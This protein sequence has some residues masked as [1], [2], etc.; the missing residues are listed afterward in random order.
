MTALTQTISTWP[1]AP[2]ADAGVARPRRW[3]SRRGWPTAP[4]C[5]ARSG[6]P[7]SP[8]RRRSSGARRPGDP[9]VE[10]AYLVAC[11]TRRP[12]AR[13][14][15]SPPC[16]RR[17]RQGA[18][19]RAGPLPDRRQAAASRRPRRR[20]A[21]RRLPT[22]SPLLA[23]RA[24]AT[25][26]PDRAAVAAGHP[27]AAAVPLAGHR[28]R[29]R[30]HRRPRLL[31]LLRPRPRRRAAARCSTTRSPCSLVFAPV[32]HL[33]RC[34]TSRSRGRLPLQR[35]PPRPD[36]G[37]H[38]PALAVVLHQRHRLLPAQPAG[39]L[40]TDLGG[41]YFNLISIL[42]LAGVYAATAARSCCWSSPPPTWRCSSSCCRS[43]VSTATSSC[44]RP[45]RRPRPVRP[46]RPSC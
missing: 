46:R 17:A 10:A 29:H 5:S 4:N 27:A 1:A 15:S 19:R 32:H 6:T 36:W 39:R 40:R 12:P 26:L 21:A 16:Q 42:A 14:S 20:G 11:L 2:A 37:R 35:R 44:Q 45:D 38:L 41:L 23:L 8:S 25:L 30:G 33:R 43:P 7:A 22:A 24:R 3:W 18:L 28:R 9:A 34:S 13:P 31:D